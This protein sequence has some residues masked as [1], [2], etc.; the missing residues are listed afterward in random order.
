[1][2][3]EDTVGVLAALVGI[4]IVL[5]VMLGSGRR[6]NTA[7]AATRVRT[8]GGP[9]LGSIIAVVGIAALVFEASKLPIVESTPGAAPLLA[10]LVVVLVVGTVVAGRITPVITAILGVGVL[11]MSLGLEQAITLVV[12]VGLLFW[13]LGLVRGW[14][15]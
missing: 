15:R 6:F 13:M 11:A 5:A 10:L 3:G 7:R 14:T 9:S 4:G 8:A 1:M 12:V 2:T